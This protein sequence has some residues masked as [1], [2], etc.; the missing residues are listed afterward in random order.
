MDHLLHKEWMTLYFDFAERHLRWKDDNVR[1]SLRLR[2]QSI[3][4]H[5]EERELVHGDFRAINKCY[6][7]DR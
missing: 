7:Q 6:G 3:V 2:L 4:Q 1:S 5:L